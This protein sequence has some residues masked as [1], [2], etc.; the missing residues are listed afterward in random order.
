MDHGLGYLAAQTPLLQTC[1]EEHTFPHVPQL[2]ESMSSEVHRA[3]QAF[4]GAGQVSLHTPW[5]HR[6]PVWH[7]APQEPQLSG[8]L[9]RSRHLPEQFVWWDWH[10]GTQLPEEQT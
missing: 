4:C 2:L 8:S 5:K 7:F 3:P 1:V 9:C 6:W 10:D